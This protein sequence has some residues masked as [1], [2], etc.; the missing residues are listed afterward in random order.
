MRACLRAQRE[1]Q[2]FEMCNTSARLTGSRS[3]A[4]DREETKDLSQEAFLRAFAHLKSFDLRSSFHTW[5]YRILV[6]LASMKRRQGS[7]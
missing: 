7:G 5:F 3:T 6:N 4:R 1:G 2:A